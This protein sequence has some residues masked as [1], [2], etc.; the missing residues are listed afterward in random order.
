[1]LVNLQTVKFR[2]L[3]SLKLIYRKQNDTTTNQ[4]SKN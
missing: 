4:I 1:M 3:F 2:V